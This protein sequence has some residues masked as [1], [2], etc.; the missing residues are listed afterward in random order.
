MEYCLHQQKLCNK[1]SW[2][3]NRLYEETVVG[4]G[5]DPAALWQDGEDDE[6]EA[7]LFV[8]FSNYFSIF[9]QL[10]RLGRIARAT[11]KQKDETFWYLN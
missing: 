9:F 1:E 2:Q 7:R 10:S 11:C 4:L 3:K 5:G 6:D 8:I